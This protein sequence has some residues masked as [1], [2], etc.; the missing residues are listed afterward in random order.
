MLRDE[1]GQW[2]TELCGKGMR[3]E[4]HECFKWGAFYSGVGV[5]VVCKWKKGNPIRLSHI[6]ESSQELLQFLVKMLSL[7][8]CLRVVGCT[9]VL[10][11]I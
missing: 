1:R 9:E 7:A 10:V 5:G 8:I 2:G 3:G 11:D 6:A 4:A